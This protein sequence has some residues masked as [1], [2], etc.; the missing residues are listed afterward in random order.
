M[1]SVEPA[2]LLQRPGGPASTPSGR[3]TRA[4]S[5]RNEP[6]FDFEFWICTSQ[7]SNFR[8]AAALQRRPAANYN[9]VPASNRDS[10]PTSPSPGLPMNAPFARKS[11]IQNRK[12]KIPVRSI[13]L[14]AGMLF[15]AALF[16]LAAR[17]VADDAAAKTGADPSAAESKPIALWPGVAPG[18]KGDIGPEKD[19]TKH[20]PKASPDSEVIRL[21]NVTKPT[22]TVFSP[23]PITT[24][25]PRLSSA[26]AAAIRSWP[27]IWKG[28]KSAAG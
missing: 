27:T 24:P 1:Q 13:M 8:F 20:N 14:A 12:S 17:S 21:T 28:P 6:I 23:A 4:W 11:K 7:I 26:P 25:A 18:D 15:V 3:S 2:E 19:S 16:S 5:R 10:P 22:I 9:A